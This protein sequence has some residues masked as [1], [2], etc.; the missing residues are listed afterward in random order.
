M[1]IDT[2][3]RER[4]RERVLFHSL[5]LIRKVYSKYVGLI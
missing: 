1:N 3:T 2:S 5:L 4:E